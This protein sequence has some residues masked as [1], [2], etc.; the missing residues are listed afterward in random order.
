MITKC[1]MDKI[2]SLARKLATEREL[3]AEAFKRG[4]EDAKVWLGAE[5]AEARAMQLSQALE[6]EQLR[7]E[8]ARLM[9]GEYICSRCGIR[10]DGEAPRVDF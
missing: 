3:R 7:L 8:N 10:K 6:W 9:R 5:L 1:L 4:Y 2:A